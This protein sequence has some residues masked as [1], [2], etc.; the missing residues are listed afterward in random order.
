M[1]NWPGKNIILFTLGIVFFFPQGVGGDE[2]KVT[3]LRYQVVMAT[4]LINQVVDKKPIT[5]DSR[6]IYEYTLQKKANQITILVHS[7]L[8]QV[9]VNG[10]V[11]VYRI[12]DR[13][14][15]RNYEKDGWKTTFAEDANPVLKQLLEHSFDRPLC[16]LEV[17]KNGKEKSR[18]MVAGSGAKELI[19]A[20]MID[21]ILMFHIPYYSSQKRWFV[22]REYKL[23]KDISVKGQVA[24]EKAK[25]LSPKE[26]HYTISGSLKGDYKHGN[27]AVKDAVYKVSGHQ[28][29]SLEKG[30]WL[31]GKHRLNIRYHVFHNGKK[32]ASARGLMV[33]TLTPVKVKSE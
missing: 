33:L 30:E 7:L 4:R 22:L 21:N 26:P 24:F 17:D 13:N 10:R 5:V 28:I 12:L 16:Q 29:Y 27:I 25:S 15:M 19:D 20:G 32:A 18:K 9:F 8:V 3:S 23:G 6:T 31:S 14:K 1:K 11:Q 2:A